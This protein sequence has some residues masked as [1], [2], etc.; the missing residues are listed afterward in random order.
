M[1]F[2]PA[3]QKP[4]LAKERYVCQLKRL[5]LILLLTTLCMSQAIGETKYV[6]MAQLK[7]ETAAG[8][9][10]TYEAHGRT[11]SVDVSVRLP[12][13]NALPIV[14]VAF[15][16]RTPILTAEESGWDEVE[17]REDV[18]LLLSHND[19]VM[20]KKLEGKAVNRS[21]KAVENWYEGF[22]PT[23]RYV[24]MCD[25][26]FG[27]ICDQLCAE[28]TRFG[29]DPADYQIDS[30]QHVWAQHWFYEGQE[31]DAFPGHILISI[32]QRIGG[33]SLLGHVL[34]TVCNHQGHETRSDE[35]VASFGLS[36]GYDGYTNQVSHMFINAA[37]VTKEIAVDVPLCNFGDIQAATQKEI[38]AG[39][40]RK[41][42]EIELG[43]VLYNQPG[44][45]RPSHQEMDYE[46][47]RFVA[48]PVWQ[49]SC[50]YADSPKAA[51][52]GTEEADERNSL[53]YRQLLIDAQTGEFIE[54]SNDYDRCEYKGFLS[55]DEVK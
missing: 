15:D 47:A 44:Q 49:L 50:L 5:L 24:P 34:D 20:P 41:V 8:W 26:S 27:E 25:I 9:H 23:N 1:N 43:Y 31:K 21:P 29:F 33:V 16:H 39:H 53:D 18:T 48:K 45:Y 30:P 55:W 35:N 37:V 10:E 40:I 14:E 38:D 22:A 6:S 17:T 51:L 2:P 32:R 4:I 12:E 36:T 19:P 52:R 11:I 3:I 13:G 7:G 54:E 46:A 28:L 42:Y